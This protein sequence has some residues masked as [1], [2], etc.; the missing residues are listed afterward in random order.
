M[1]SSFTNN[2]DGTV[3]IT[4]TFTGPIERVNNTVADAAQH[5]WTCGYAVDGR[6]FAS[7]SANEKLAL[8]ERYMLRVTKDAARTQYINAAGASARLAAANEVS[9]RHLEG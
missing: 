8:V 6:T 1:A 9:T 4:I 5:L 3:T 7:L 2:G